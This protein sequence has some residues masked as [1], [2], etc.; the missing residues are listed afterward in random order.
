MGDYSEALLEGSAFSPPIVRFDV[1]LGEA[2]KRG[3]VI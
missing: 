3:E 2:T 1:E